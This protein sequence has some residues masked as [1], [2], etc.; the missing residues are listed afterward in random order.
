LTGY[1]FGGVLGFV[2]PGFTPRFAGGGT[3]F[4]GRPAGPDFGKLLFSGLGLIS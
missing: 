2:A 3:G 1:F 4:G